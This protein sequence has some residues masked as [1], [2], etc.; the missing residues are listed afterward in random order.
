L[1]ESSFS[2]EE[3]AIGLFGGAFDPP[4]LGHV[5]LLQAAHRELGLGRVLVL[6]SADPGHKRVGT[7]ALDRLA[8]AR[9]AFPA[10][11]VELDVHPRTVD[12][13]R[14]HPEWEDPVF[15]LGAD[16]FCDF[17]DWKEPAE[18]LRRAR[19]G[20]ATRPGYPAERLEPVLARLETPERV[21]FF[22]LEPV[23]VAS[24]ELRARLASGDDVA[25][26]LPPAVAAEIER[27][28]LY[29]APPGR[30]DSA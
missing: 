18:V 28:G 9:A 19:L 27:R 8:L 13:L 29:R 24:R 7:P 12:L 1:P 3:G 10:E 6:V 20:V 26:A 30:L 14:A 23:P 21:L 16:E 11:R 17:L 4:H 15:L 2:A 25:D 22:E 5:A